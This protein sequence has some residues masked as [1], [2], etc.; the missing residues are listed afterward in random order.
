MGRLRCFRRV[1]ERARAAP[2]PTGCT[3]DG[4]LYA[5]VNR[6]SLDAPDRLMMSLWAAKA[7]WDV[8]IT[9]DGKAEAARASKRRATD[10][11]I[12]GHR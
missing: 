3:Q 12:I 8:T 9:S 11:I 5:K 6:W 1:A 4:K 2:F 7:G 10:A